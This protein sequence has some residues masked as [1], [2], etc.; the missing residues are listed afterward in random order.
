[1]AELGYKNY[2]QVLNAK[3]YGIPQHRERVF[4]ISIRKDCNIDFSFPRPQ[5][6]RYLLKDLLEPT[7]DEAYYLADEKIAKM[8]A[9][10]ELMQKK[11]YGFR[12]GL[13]R[14]V[15][16]TLSARD[17]KDSKCIKIGDIT[18]KF[19]STNR[20]Y[21]PEGLSPTITTM[22]GGNQEPKIVVMRGRNLDN[23]SDRTTGVHTEQRLEV[24]N[25]STSNT[26]TSVQKDN[27]VL[28]PTYR[29]RKLTERE[30]WR[31]MGFDD[32]DVDKVKAIGMSK[33]QMYKQ[34]GNS[35]CV[36]VLE[37]LLKELLS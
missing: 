33:T 36:P 6:L 19:E 31:L 28:E 22:G 4:T 1:M 14:A 10:T 35:I 13:E 29:I 21:S 18:S 9:R 37:A 8:R 26:L 34:A 3:H 32:N 30:C 7:V 5:V 27:L 16:S 17:Y 24:N 23:P 15:C 20:V 11:G 12:Y 25:K 2:Y